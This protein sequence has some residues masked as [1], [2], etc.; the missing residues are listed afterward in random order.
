MI[1]S[2][3]PNFCNVVL[4]Q[5][6]DRSN[7]ACANTWPWSAGPPAPDINCPTGAMPPS[8][9]VTP[10]SF[11]DP[12]A[13]GMLDQDK[14]CDAEFRTQ[15]LPP[16][17]A[18]TLLNAAGAISTI[19]A[20]FTVP[21][22]TDKHATT[23]GVGPTGTVF[24]YDFD[25]TRWVGTNGVVSALSVGSEGSVWAIVNTTS[26]GS[27]EG[28][29]CAATAGSCLN[30]GNCSWQCNWNEPN[31]FQW[32]QIAAGAGT[33]IWA[34]DSSRFT[35]YMHPSDGGGQYDG[36]QFFAMN[37]WPFNDP[38]NQM[39]VGGD[40][41]LWVVSSL[42][43]ITEFSGGVFTPMPSPPGSK[44]V[45]IA[46]GSFYDVWAASSSGLFHWNRNTTSWEKHCLV[47]GCNSTPFTTVAVGTGS[48]REVSTQTYGVDI[49]VWALDS[50]GHT[51]RVDKTKG[52]TTN[53]I[54]QV[55]GTLT[56]IA[57]GGQGDVWGINSAGTVLTFQ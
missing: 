53:S 33:S 34:V 7:A 55:P 38:I 27:P 19:S 42:G 4:S 51:Y 18:G 28:F 39:S 23:Y 32:S 17:G 57:V 26:G 40:G 3:I 14:Q 6:V 48:P 15:W 49:D 16:P 56:Q 8:S 29:T 45:S 21:G 30:A 9:S 20:T 44:V 54:I 43:N 47:S 2:Q 36:T 41:N 10:P 12:F 24:V 1:S 37:E 46:V 52:T 50:S 13:T 35:I 11:S 5:A 22:L 31:A 25:N